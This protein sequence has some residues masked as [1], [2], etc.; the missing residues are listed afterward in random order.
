MIDKVQTRYLYASL[1]FLAIIVYAYSI[2]F[3]ITSYDDSFV[4]YA[5]KIFYFSNIKKIFFSDVMLN[6]SSQMYRPLMNLS[7]IWDTAWGGG[8]HFFHFTNILLNSFAVIC[9]FKILLLLKTERITAFLL[10]LFFLLHPSVAEAVAWIPGRN[11]IIAA[12]FSFIAFISFIKYFENNKLEY[13]CLFSVFLLCAILTKE[14]CLM[15]VPVA[16]FYL[17]LFKKDVLSGKKIFYFIPFFLFP[18]IIYSILK[19]IVFLNYSSPKAI[20]VFLT[21]KNFIYIPIIASN[22]LFP[23]NPVTYKVLSYSNIDSYIYYL[24]LIAL[25]VCAA[26]IMCLNTKDKRKIL[27]GALWFILFLIPTFVEMKQGKPPFI[28][29]RR[30]Y[31]PLLGLIIMFSDFFSLFIN[32]KDKR[33]VFSY[34]FIFIIF[35]ACNSYI[36]CQNYRNQYNFYLQASKDSPKLYYPYFVLGKIEYERDLYAAAEPYLSKALELE[37][38]DSEIAYMLLNIYLNKRDIK[39]SE[40]MIKI[41]IEQLKNDT[42]IPFNDKAKQIRQIINTFNY[43]KYLSKA[44]NGN[45]SIQFHLTAER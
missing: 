29:E 37:P 34:V 28:Y 2:S 25:F 9:V 43:I 5:E 14:T 1:F 10:S 30:S 40:K 7:F 6:N 39:N 19:Y 33:I 8:V 15:I 13:K 17:Y 18:Y 20:S 22:N 23:F 41:I 32:G 36:Y 21:L 38:S 4:L 12:L 44:K 27:F 3:G 24:V 11:D 16:F 26:V 35:F 45:F 42:N 31:L